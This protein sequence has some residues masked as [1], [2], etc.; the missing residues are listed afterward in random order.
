MS[1]VD[2]LQ[3]ALEIVYWAWVRNGDPRVTAPEGYV[4]E[5]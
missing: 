4:V 2:D 5:E 1:K 3:L